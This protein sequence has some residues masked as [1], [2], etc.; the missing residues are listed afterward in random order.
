MSNDLVEEYRAAMLH[1]D[2]EIS[3]LMV[4][5]QQVEESGHKSMHRD[6]KRARS[7]EE[8]TLKGRLQIKDKPKF[9]ENFSNQVS[10]NFLKVIN[11]RVSNSKSQNGKCGD[12]TSK[13]PIYTKCDKND[14]S[15]LGRVIIFIVVR[16]II[17]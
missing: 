2:M 11:K 5:A 3:H 12:S 4:H 6:A 17:R 14:V 16:V 7:N 9:K 10:S 15:K 1:N 8:G 13:K